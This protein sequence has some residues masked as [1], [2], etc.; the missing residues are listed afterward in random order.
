MTTQEITTTMRAYA[1]DRFGPLTDLELREVPVP[2]PGA[3]EVLV[4]VTAAGVDPSIWHL[5]TANPRMVR[6]V[7]GRWGRPKW[8]VPG[9]DL[10]GTVV[11][12]GPSVTELSVGDRVVGQARGT[13]Q[14]YAVA[15]VSTLV[16]VPDPLDLTA[17]AALPVSGVTAYQ[18]VES[19]QPGP[20]KRIAVIGAGGGVGGFAVQLA[21]RAG[22][23][24]TAVCSAGK[25]DLVRG[26]GASEV[27]DYRATD[28]T[29]SGRTF[30]GI[31]E[32]AGRRPQGSLR[33]LLTKRGRLVVVGGEPTGTEWLGMG[34]ML[35][36]T[37][38]NPFVP[39]HLHGLVA[40]MP[41]E[42]LQELVD[43]LA[44]GDLR[45]PLDRAFP[46]EAAV[47]AVQFVRD[48]HP[49]GKVVVAVGG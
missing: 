8:P 24:V 46:F 47:E 45:V 43:L 26:L 18:A 42:T 5:V 33:R 29:E 36:A 28:V 20:G 15:P 17:V 11:R 10:S 49:H 41:K 19:V 16:T 40:T 25:A 2:Q 39:Q 9:W 31:I 1:Q 6:L 13:F 23:E 12:V 37:L 44:A 30:D 22:A 32:L 7:W 4:Q 34:R 38:S 35:Q 48:G 27:I 3:G 21:A 14:E